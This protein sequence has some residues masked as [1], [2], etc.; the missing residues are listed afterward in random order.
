M[1]H[2]CSEGHFIHSLS[3]QAATKFNLNI[4]SLVELK[5]SGVQDCLG[6]G[7]ALEPLGS[8]DLDVAEVLVA[9]KV[10]VNAGA[11]VGIE[12]PVAT[13]VLLGDKKGQF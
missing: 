9:G 2:S 5:Q 11:D 3:K 8:V 7:L 13:G 12:D 6:L 1:K 4:E 10:R